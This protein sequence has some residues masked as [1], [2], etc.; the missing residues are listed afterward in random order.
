MAKKKKQK[1]SQKT[2]ENNEGI[3]LQEQLNQEMLEKLKAAKKE[4]LEEERKKEEERQARL[5]FERKQREK[6]MSFEELL[7]KYGNQGSKFS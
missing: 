5:E 3:S 6:N 4:L 7:E 1:S 2:I